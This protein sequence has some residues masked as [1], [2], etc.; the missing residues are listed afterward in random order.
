MKKRSVNKGLAFKWSR[1]Q[2][3]KFRYPEPYD[4]YSAGTL[5]EIDAPDGST[6][7]LVM[8][9]HFDEESGLIRHYAIEAP[10]GCPMREAF[11]WGEF[12]WDEYWSH[13]DHLYE[14]IIPFNHG[15][16]SSRIISPAEISQ[17][18]KLR[19]NKL[20]EC[21]PFE[22]KRRHLELGVAY[23]IIDAEERAEAQC[24]YDAFME[25]YG[26]RFSKRAA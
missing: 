6:T 9:D 14:I 12:T 21:F 24:K 18:A 7:F 5:F 2:F 26:H 25:K 13:K 4:V 16:V 15:P 23:A 19:F 20:G 17:N 10:A 8:Q 1:E 3:A 11:E 22:L